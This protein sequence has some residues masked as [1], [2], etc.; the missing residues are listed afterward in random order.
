MMSVKF[1]D[2]DSRAAEPYILVV[3]APDGVDTLEIV[4]DIL[5]QRAG[6]RAVEDA[7]SPGVELDGVV[8]IVH[9]GLHGFVHSHAA[10]VDFLF[11]IELSAAAH[12]G[13]GR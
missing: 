8:D 13:C 10:D 7:Y 5:P 2:G 9:Y 12:F 1:Y 11:E 3:E 6:A 4:A